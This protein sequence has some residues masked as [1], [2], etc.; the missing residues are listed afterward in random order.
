MRLIGDILDYSKIESGQLTLIN[1]VF[2]VESLVIELTNHY[3]NNITSLSQ[4][5]VNLIFKKSGGSFELNGDKQRLKQIL[6]NLINNAIKFTEK[7]TIE[8]NYYFENQQLVFYVR[9]S[10]IGISQKQLQVIF[11]RFWQA[12]PPKSKIYGGTGLG[13]AIS[14]GL[15]TLMRGDIYVESILGIGSTFVVKLPSEVT[16]REM[17]NKN[18]TPQQII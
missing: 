2:N 15:V 11:E 12:A 13:L 17:V 10:G 18:D 3:D 1:D 5:G 6:V 14:K 9:D 7:G 16:Q 8:V 4:K